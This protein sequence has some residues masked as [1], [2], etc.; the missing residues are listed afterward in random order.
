MNKLAFCHCKIFQTNL[1]LD[2]IARQLSLSL[3]RGRDN[4]NIPET[5]L[6]S[7]GCSYLDFIEPRYQLIVARRPTS[8]GVAAWNLNSCSA[9]VT[10]RHRRG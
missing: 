3:G 9:R 7:P 10:S 1:A 8:N 2:L 5:Q 4:D 6:D